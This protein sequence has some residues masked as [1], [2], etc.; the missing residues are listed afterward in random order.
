MEEI[1]KAI[2]DEWAIYD[3][4]SKTPILIDEGAKYE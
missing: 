1:Y 2:V 4:S 3:N